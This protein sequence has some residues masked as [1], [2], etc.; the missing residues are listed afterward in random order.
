MQLAASAAGGS[1]VRPGESGLAVS[2]TPNRQPDA[3]CLLCSACRKTGRDWMRQQ[4][5]CGRMCCFPW[6]APYGICPP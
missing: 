2:S 6:F 1:S 3:S 4:H 5:D